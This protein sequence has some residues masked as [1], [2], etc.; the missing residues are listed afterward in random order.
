MLSNKSIF[1]AL[2]LLST[3]ILSGCGGNDSSSD[4][5]IITD[6]STTDESTNAEN[7]TTTYAI[8]GTLSNLPIGTSGPQCDILRLDNMV[9]CVTD[10]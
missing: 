9:R 8:S 4:D 1:S 7:T 6:N 2:V 3:L 5:Y 10:I